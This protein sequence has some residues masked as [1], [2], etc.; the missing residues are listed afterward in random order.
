MAVG[1][2]ARRVTGVLV[3]ACTAAATALAGTATAQEAEADVTVEVSAPRNILP[4]GGWTSVYTR[5]RNVGTAPAEDV[6]FTVTLPSELQV[7][8]TETSS[9]WDCESPAP[10]TAT[11][12]HVGPLQ[13]GATPF[14][15]RFSA[16]VAYQAPIGTSVIA[17]ASVTTGS[18][19]SVT[20]NN[21]S[22]RSFTFVGKGV[23]KGRIWHDL[24]AN[25]VREPNEP[26]VDS[27]GISF[28]ALD[29]EDS[30]GFSNTSQGQYRLDLAAKRFQAHV[31]LSKNSWR[32][33]TPNVGND[34]ADS[35][36][37]PT[38]EDAWYRHGSSE[39]FTVEAGAEHVVDVG[40]VAVPTNSWRDIHNRR[41]LP[42]PVRATR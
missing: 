40:V 14:H 31:S 24:N 38:T 3:I 22:A 11:C 32:L 21:E 29:D 27:I 20:T 28:R 1:V 37:V 7:F 19:E 16:G 25:G 42:W 2:L 35:D 5:V 17:T 4:P 15:F 9:E 39:V 36:I 12:E 6:R 18:P 26:P 8:G 23:V 33:T 13:P 30:A 10:G 34:T 41:P